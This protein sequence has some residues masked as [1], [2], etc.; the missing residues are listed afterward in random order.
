MLYSDE[1]WLSVRTEHY[2]RGLLLLILVL[3]RVR[4]PIAWHKVMGGP[5]GEGIRYLVEWVDIPVGDVNIQNSPV[6]PMVFRTKLQMVASG[7]ETSAKADRV[8][9]S[10]PGTVLRL[11]RGWRRVREAEVAGLAF[12]RFQVPGGGTQESPRYAL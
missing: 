10:F 11:L 3:V 7:C 8:H 12:H 1:G 9:S 2:E 4:L 5:S 6:L